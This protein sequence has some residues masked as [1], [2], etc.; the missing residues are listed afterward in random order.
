MW[1]SVEHCKYIKTA[2]EFGIYAVKS[3]MPGS[4][5]WRILE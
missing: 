1:K 5:K 4:S 2:L 3:V